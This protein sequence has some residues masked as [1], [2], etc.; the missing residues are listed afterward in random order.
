MGGGRFYSP[1]PIFAPDLKNFFSKYRLYRMPRDASK[2]KTGKPKGN[3]KGKSKKTYKKNYR[4]NSYVPSVVNLFGRKKVKLEYVETIILSSDSSGAL[5]GYT[6]SEYV[7]NLNSLY[8]PNQTGTGHQPYGFD[9]L[10]L[11]YQLYTV[12]GAHI[13]I[14]VSNPSADGAVFFMSVQASNPNYSLSS[15]YQDVIWEKN[16]A[17]G[18]PINNTGSQVKRI[19]RYYPIHKIEKVL[20]QKVLLDDQYSSN[21]TS[22]PVLVPVVRVALAN[23]TSTATLTAV[24]TM[25]LTYYTMFGEPFIL[26]QS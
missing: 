20:K 3:I 16:R 1:P 11:L 2:S 23:S 5:Q 6:G 14:T 26:S 24:C 15:Q 18:F 22:S 7:W 8:D 12:Y 4:R 19:K 13:D 17:E 10:K 21:I 25:K 9:Q